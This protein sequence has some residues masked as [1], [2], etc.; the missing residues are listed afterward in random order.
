MPHC[1]RRPVQEAPWLHDVVFVAFDAEEHG[2][3]GRRAF[4]APPPIPKERLA[5]NINMD[6]VA[7]AT[8]AR[9]YVAGTLTSSRLRKRCLSRLPTCRRSR[10]LFGHDRRTAGIGRLDHAVGSRRVSRAGIPFLYFGVE[11]HPDYHKPTDT[12]DKIDP[13]FFFQS[14]RDR[15]STRSARS[16]GRCRCRAPVSRRR[17][18]AARH[19]SSA[20]RPAVRTV[21]RRALGHRSDPDRAPLR[22]RG[23]SRRWSASAPRRWPSGAC[24]ACST[25]SRA[26]CR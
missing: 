3:A 24:R 8:R 25:R 14:A 23:R 9:L 1:Y 5:L 7:A 21:Q 12:A 17:A 15:R 16:I 11:D 2:A 22:P 18:P 4:V 6:M 19:R 13:A 26:C 10:C 20:P